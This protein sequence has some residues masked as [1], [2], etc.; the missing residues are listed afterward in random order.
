M[1]HMYVFGNAMM[2]GYALCGLHGLIYF[3]DVNALVE[4]AGVLQVMGIAYGLES[5]YLGFQS[6]K[7][8][9]QP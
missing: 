3:G 4:V 2:A 8:E 1:R 9:T 7:G 5:L 6:A